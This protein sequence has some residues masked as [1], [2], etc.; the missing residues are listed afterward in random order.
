VRPSKRRVY[1][2]ERDARVLAGLASYRFLTARQIKA[3]HTFPSLKATSE[4]LRKL[5]G[6]GIVSRVFAPLKISRRDL[7]AAYA[8][9]ARG[10]KVLATRTGEPELA[11]LTVRD[12][13]SAIM[14]MHTLRRNDVRIIF[15]LLQERAV[16]QA[17]WRQGK[18]VEIR[19]PAR[20]RIGRRYLRRAIPDGL[21]SVFLPGRCERFLVELDRATVAARKMADR[22]GIYA[23]YLRGGAR[24]GEIGGA[25]A[26]VL[27]IVPHASRRERLRSAVLE[28][29]GRAA[30]SA[31]WFTTLDDA[32][33]LDDPE[34]LLA[35]VWWRAGDKKGPYP[36]FSTTYAQEI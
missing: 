28:D 10:A 32:V 14:L 35:P 17:S 7:E 22:Y 20:T 3:L 2:T 25:P 26:R 30:K 8:L 19:I 4:R 5:Q 23:A 13:R 11:H 33:D 21:V 1:I 27:T 36:L 9:S 6:A 12:E 34:K 15:E 16:L 29:A 31:F 18:D 24:G